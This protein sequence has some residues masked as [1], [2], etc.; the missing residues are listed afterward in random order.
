MESTSQTNVE[1]NPTES[2]MK[3]YSEFCKTTFS[4]ERGLWILPSSLSVFI[5]DILEGVFDLI[6]G[7]KDERSTGESIKVIEKLGYEVITKNAKINSDDSDIDLAK[8][9]GV[10]TI[11]DWI[12]AEEGTIGGFILCQD[13]RI[14]A[15]LSY[16]KII[17][18]MEIKDEDKFDVERCKRFS[19]VLKILNSLLDKDNIKTVI[20]AGRK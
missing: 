5:V 16:H 20:M 4:S 17:K 19:L 9:V 2:D 11:L 15:M 12:G 3:I 1:Y 8:E 14:D 10:Q 18:D 13:L 7:N 6:A